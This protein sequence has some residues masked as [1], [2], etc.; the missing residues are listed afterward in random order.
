MFAVYSCRRLISFIL[1]KIYAD[2]VE[3]TF[4]IPYA[5]GNLVSYFRENA[6]L[7][8]QEYEENGTKLTVKCHKADK[9]KYADYL[10]KK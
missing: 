9:N 7:I 5:K 2:Y 4:L 3:E 8:S 6:H 1:N 10:Y